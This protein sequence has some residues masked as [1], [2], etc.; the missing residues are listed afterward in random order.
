MLSNS[1]NIFLEIELGRN[2]T[3]NLWIREG[4][5][6]YH[7]F[8]IVDQW[9]GIFWKI[10]Q[11]LKHFGIV[12]GRLFAVHK[13]NL[14]GAKSR[15]STVVH[16]F[17]LELRVQIKIAI[18]MYFR[19]HLISGICWMQLLP[20]AYFSS[21]KLAMHFD[22]VFFCQIILGHIFI[23][24]PACVHVR[25]KNKFYRIF[26]A[27]KQFLIQCA[28][29]LNSNNQRRF[30]FNDVELFICPRSFHDEIQPSIH[31]IWLHSIE[32]CRYW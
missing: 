26:V 21:F 27:K 6:S 23:R 2:W 32:H 12:E 5:K 8:W 25:I 16:F 30:N 14:I 31:V 9:R 20:G 29:S 17:P 3:L 15:N 24:I 19:C 11:V 1:Q 7:Y 18:R 28:L 4:R 13:F 22:N 10:H